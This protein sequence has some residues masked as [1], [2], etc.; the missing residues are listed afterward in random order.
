LL[1]HNF[2]PQQKSAF[3]RCDP[4]ETGNVSIAVAE[5]CQIPHIRSLR[6]N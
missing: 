3:G 4:P 5:I 6:W 1:A 2:V